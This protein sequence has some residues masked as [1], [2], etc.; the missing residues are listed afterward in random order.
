[1]QSTQ[2]MMGST[3]VWASMQTEQETTQ[4]MLPSLCKYKVQNYM[5][6]LYRLLPVLTLDV[7]Y[8]LITRRLLAAIVL[9][10]VILLLQGIFYRNLYFHVILLSWNLWSTIILHTLSLL[11]PLQYHQRWRSQQ[12]SQGLWW[13]TPPPSPALSP[14]ATPWAATPT[15]G[16]TTTRSLSV[17]LVAR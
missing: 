14:E 5:H 6:A 11:P 15:D 12:L 4:T 17:K 13:G 8:C 1:M 2:H 16:C 10:I 9:P 7:I 3:H